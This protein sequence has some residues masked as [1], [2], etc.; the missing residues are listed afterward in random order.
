MAELVDGYGMH[1]Y[2]DANPQRTVATRIDSLDQT[3][4]ARCRQGGKPCWL[5]E[6]G[7]PRAANPD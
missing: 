1:V 4:F 5:T 6:W 3:I 2:P 7:F